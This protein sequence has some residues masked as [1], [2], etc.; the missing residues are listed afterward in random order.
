MHDAYTNALTDNRGGEGVHVYDG[1]TDGW[2]DR[3]QRQHVMTSGAVGGQAA[4]ST[5][6][7]SMNS[8]T[9]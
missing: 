3:T 8:A 9:S 7:L 6:L 1:Y 2:I 5:C 4:S